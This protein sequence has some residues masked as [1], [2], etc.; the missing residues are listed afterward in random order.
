MSH[1]D[2][3][4][5]EDLVTRIECLQRELRSEKAKVVQLSDLLDVANGQ[6]HRQSKVIAELRRC[7]REQERELERVD[8]LA[9]KFLL[10]EALRV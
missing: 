4:S 9:A 6:N 7:N 2:D 8:K 1:Y 10:R 3:Y 5:H